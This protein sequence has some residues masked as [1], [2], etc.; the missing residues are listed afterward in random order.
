MALHLLPGTFHKAHN[1]GDQELG[2]GYTAG[3]DTGTHDG[4]RSQ[5]GMGSATSND[6]GFGKT[7]IPSSPK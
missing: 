7:G 3:D 5:A 1:A 6:T 2:V 4:Q